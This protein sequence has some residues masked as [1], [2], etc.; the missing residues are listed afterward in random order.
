MGQPH[1]CRDVSWQR[2]SAAKG[3]R[4]QPNTRTLPHRSKFAEARSSHGGANIKRVTV[5]LLP[6]S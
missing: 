2:P 6:E 1:W 5:E 3:T 4:F